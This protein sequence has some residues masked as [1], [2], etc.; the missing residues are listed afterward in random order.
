[1]AADGDSAVGLQAIAGLERLVHEPGRLL[2]LACLAVVTRADFLYVMR[3][4]GLSQGNLSSHLSKLESAGYVSVEK[5]FVGKV[6]RTVLQLTEAGREALRAYRNRLVEAL[7][8]LP[9]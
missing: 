1:M 8:R 4:T 2:V 6:P 9:E 7:S 5:T 3:E